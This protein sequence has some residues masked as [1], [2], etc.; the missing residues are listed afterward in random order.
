M[1]AL[2]L[3][4]VILAALAEHALALTPASIENPLKRIL[5]Y[6]IVA[7]EIAIGY[8]K[9]LIGKFPFTWLAFSTWFRM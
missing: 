4:W 9:T 6:L 8:L 1:I 5:Y 7:P 2:L 3:I